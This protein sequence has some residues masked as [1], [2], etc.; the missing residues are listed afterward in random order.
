MAELKA[1]AST[2]DDY[3]ARV[4]ANPIAL[5]VKLHDIASNAN[6]KRLALLDQAT[7]DRLT[8]KYAHALAV[9]S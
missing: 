4:K 3:Y 7:R 6:P 2:R 8:L 1:P 9:L 5:R